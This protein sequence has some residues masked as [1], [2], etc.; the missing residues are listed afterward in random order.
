MQHYAPCEAV[1][2]LY[3]QYI[4]VWFL[5]KDPLRN[6]SPRI[7][8]VLR[9]WWISDADNN[10]NSFSLKELLTNPKKLKILCVVHEQI[11]PKMV[12]CHNLLRISDF[13]HALHSSRWK[14]GARIAAILVLCI[15]SREAQSTFLM[16]I[17]VVLPTKSHKYESYFGCCTTQLKH[18]TVLYSKASK[19]LNV[20]N[21]CFKH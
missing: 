6:I 1:L 20:S 7:P 19:T 11:V 16:P 2:L 3:E 10:E 13:S 4:T 15:T 21:P 18:N 14:T 12:K 5:R 17:T 8:Q 9:Q